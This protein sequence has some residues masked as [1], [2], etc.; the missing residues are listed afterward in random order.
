MNLMETWIITYNNYSI[1]VNLTL[2]KSRNREY[3][4]DEIGN[5]YIKIFKILEKMENTDNRVELYY[6]N[7][8][9]EPLEF[10]LQ[11]LWGF[12]KNSNFHIYWFKSKKCS[13]PK[14]DNKNKLGSGLRY[15]NSQCIIHGIKTLN[16]IKRKEKLNRILKK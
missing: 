8:Q 6:L 2:L 15:I 9:L 7:E 5:T 1:N 3:L 11:D 13:C 10:K 14:L 4:K 12:D 16:I